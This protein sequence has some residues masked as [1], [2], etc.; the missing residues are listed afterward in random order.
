MSAAAAPQ[1]DAYVLPPHYRNKRCTILVTGAS[2]S[3]KAAFINAATLVDEPEEG[4][5]LVEPEGPIRSSHPF[6]LDSGHVVTLLDVSLSKDKGPE[7]QEFF[8]TQY[9]N[10]DLT[11]GIIYLHSLAD[12]DSAGRGAAFKTM[13][14]LC[15]DQ[16]LQNTIIATTD[17]VTEP[18][19]ARKKQERWEKKLTNTLFASAV[20]KGARIFRHKE[21]TPAAARRI[22]KALLGRPPILVGVQKQLADEALRLHQT[23]SGGILLGDISVEGGNGVPPET[24]DG[25]YGHEH[26][27]EH[28]VLDRSD[29]TIRSASQRPFIASRS[30]LKPPHSG[31]V[32]G[33]GH[34]RSTEHKQKLKRWKKQQ[35]NRAWR[36]AQEKWDPV[37]MVA[38]VCCGAALYAVLTL[39]RE[40]GAFLIGL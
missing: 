7:L 25:E 5:T 30:S 14:D 29:G 11:T 28:G 13:K 3:V 17:W 16:A 15:G 38:C 39:A 36:V 24:Q 35:E 2:P 20:T 8:N 26:E 37:E 6:E 1:F 4:Q 22:V 23:E 21:N 10:G 12:D 19:E 31:Y 33:A 40:H 9:Q 34:R 18:S 27:Y 32:T